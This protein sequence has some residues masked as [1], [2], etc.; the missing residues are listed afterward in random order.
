MANNINNNEFASL[1][2]ALEGL[3]KETIPHVW[4]ILFGGE[5]QESLDIPKS[6]T[7]KSVENN[8][9]VKTYKIECP[10]E[11][12]RSAR[13]VRVGVI[14]NT[15]V[16]PTTDPV[17]EQYLAI[18][19]KVE[20][21]IEAAA[22]LGVNVLCLQEAWTCPF[23]FC[24]RERYPWCEFAED[25]KTGRSTSFLKEVRFFLSFL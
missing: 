11:Q 21:M 6:V 13:I 18:Q 19:D 7:E 22:E 17:L 15:I 14:Q 5:K 9:E 2:D 3:P 20:K 12:L 23:F 8:F 4:R 10:K 1:E 25:A 24:T 16:K